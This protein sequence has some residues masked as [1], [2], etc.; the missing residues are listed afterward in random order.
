MNSKNFLC[1][2][3]AVK[4]EIYSA[5][6][7]LAFNKIKNRK[8][9]APQE[10]FKVLALLYSA[11]TIFVPTSGNYWQ[12]KNADRREVLGKDSI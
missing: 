4:L 7:A 10:A 5:T 12:E 9:K 11:L 2:G 8:A 3:S 6:K 1:N